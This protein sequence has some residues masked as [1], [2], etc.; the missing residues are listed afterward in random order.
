MQR[1]T[2]P[3]AQKGSWEY[4]LHKAA[5]ANGNFVPSLMPMRYDAFLYIDETTALHPLH[6]T[7]DGHLVP[8]TYPFGM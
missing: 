5:P 7:P 4:L 1:M 3:P 6:I 8:E 2:V